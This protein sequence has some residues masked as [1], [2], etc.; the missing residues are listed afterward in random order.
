MWGFQ[1]LAPE[2]SFCINH[3]K[4]VSVLTPLTYPFPFL[5]ACSKRITWGPKPDHVL[6]A[7]GGQ[8][9]K[10]RVTLYAVDHV[11]QAG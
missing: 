8:D 2:S 4:C 7:T 5:S 9:W 11:L 6:N 1:D 3:A 10:V